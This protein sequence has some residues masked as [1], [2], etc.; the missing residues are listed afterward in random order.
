MNDCYIF[1][2]DS[3]TFEFY[4]RFFARRPVSVIKKAIKE[5]AD[6]IDNPANFIYEQDNMDEFHCLYR[7]L[8]NKMKEMEQEKVNP[9]RVKILDSVLTYME[10]RVSFGYS[11]EDERNG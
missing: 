9:A 6:M 1:R 4:E 7:D 8:W 11:R 2:S 10:K 3:V 5:I